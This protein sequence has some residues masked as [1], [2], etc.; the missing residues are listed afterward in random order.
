MLKLCGKNE[1]ELI[2]PL[3]DE[4]DDDADDDITDTEMASHS[5]AIVFRS[6]V[7]FLVT[8]ISKRK[9]TFVHC[10]KSY[11]KLG[12]RVLT[13]VLQTQCSQIFQIRKFVENYGLSLVFLISSK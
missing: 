1:K 13:K 12:Q 3:D 4:G 2:A 9:S 7:K 6:F 10:P 8:G 5:F 11:V